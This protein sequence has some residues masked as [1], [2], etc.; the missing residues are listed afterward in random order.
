MTQTG[1]TH[2]GEASDISLSRP[3]RPNVATTQ[4]PVIIIGAGI[5]GLCLAQGLK[6]AGRDFRVFERDAAL[7]DRPQGYR[8]KIEENGAEALRTTLTSACFEA[9]TAACAVTTTG[10]TDYNPV[11]GNITNSRAGSG[12]AGRQ[13]LSATYT[14][15][16]EVFRT[17]LMTGIADCITFGK[18]L[19]SYD[20]TSDG[21]AV[22]AT[23][24]DGSRVHGSFLVGADGVR[25]SVRKQMLPELKYVDTG[26]V[27]IYGKTPITPALEAEFPAKAL[28][29]MTAYV[30]R[31]PSIQAI[32]IGDSPLTLLS[33]PIRFSEQSRALMRLPEDYVYWA[34]IGRK[35]LFT[36]T[37][38][39]ETY[40]ASQAA[41]F[42]LEL[43]KEWD[44]SMSALLR[45]QD[46]TQCSAMPVVSAMPELPT[47]QP[48]DRVTLVSL[49]ILSEN[50]RLIMTHSSETQF[51]PCHLVEVSRLEPLIH[52]QLMPRQVWGPTQ[53]SWMQ[54]SWPSFS[55]ARV[56]VMIS[57]PNQ[58][59]ITKP[60]CES[61]PLA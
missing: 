33:E 52:H 20:L 17:I 47:W 59:G 57:R 25:S 31:A 43:T 2:G 50:K 58:S 32:L 40:S 35:E 29:W 23:F 48:S 61:E 8:L 5:G 16:R 11:N 55:G 24:R 45:L 10:Q 27:C 46:F 18:Q 15:D 4:E 26:A 42:S 1:I 36:D 21:D 14:V 60:Q 30:D 44:D 19:E 49:L 54:Q 22:L 37:T 6:R 3:G 41:K 12:L 53:L 28:R 38:P 9:F 56:V 39:V 51:T 34:M 7:H 13:G